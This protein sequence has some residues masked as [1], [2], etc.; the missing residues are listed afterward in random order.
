M[1]NY[2]WLFLSLLVSTSGFARVDF[3]TKQ[4]RV[5]SLMKLQKQAPAFAFDSFQREL[6]Y[7]KQ[8]LSLDKRAKKEAN[9]LADQ[10]RA[11]VIDAYEAALKKYEKR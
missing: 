3:K 5:D 1:L 2:R 7:E 9:L 11:R 6:E 10:I 4:A 8:G